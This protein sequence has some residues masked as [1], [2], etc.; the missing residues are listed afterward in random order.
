MTEADF[1]LAIQGILEEAVKE[2]FTVQDIYEM[3]IETVDEWA[4]ETGLFDDDD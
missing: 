1:Y 4:E 3:A 2:D